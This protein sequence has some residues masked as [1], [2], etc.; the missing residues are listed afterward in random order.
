MMFV[1]FLD[2]NINIV[3]ILYI[4]CRSFYKGWFWT[5]KHN[6]LMFVRNLGISG[7]GVILKAELNG[8]LFVGSF[9]DH[10]VSL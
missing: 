4:N 3:G 1:V 6:G 7:I 9:G 10:S 8:P 5:L 2:G